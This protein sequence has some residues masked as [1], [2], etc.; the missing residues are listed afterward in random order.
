MNLA[1]NR[2]VM[3][4]KRNAIVQST[5]HRLFRLIL[6]ALLA[7]SLPVSLATAAP[8]PTTGNSIFVVDSLADDPDTDPGDGLCETGLGECTLRAAIMEAQS[9]A[10]PGPDT[11]D[12]SGL[13]GTI[14]L[15]NMLPFIESEL[16]I[17]GPEDADTLLIDGDYFSQHFRVEST[18]ALELI[19]MHLTNGSSKGN[20]GSIM[21]S[22]TLTLTGVIITNSSAGN[23]G[24][25]I[26]GGAGSVT[27]IDGGSEI[28]RVE[29]GNYASYG[30]GIAI[31]S[32][33]LTVD[34]SAISYNIAGSGGG[35][36][37]NWSGSVTIR[38]GS[39]IEGNTTQGSG[40]GDGQ[41][42]G[43]YNS[44]SAS[45]QIED[46]TLVGNSGRNGGGIYNNYSEATLV[47]TTVS[48]NLAS[49]SGGGIYED[50]ADSLYLY[51]VTIT[52]NTAD[53]NESGFGNGGGLAAGGFVYMYNTILA[54][55]EDLTPEG[56]VH[57]DC[58]VFNIAW[59][60]SSYNIVGDNAGCED[61]LING[62]N[63]NQ[64]GNAN[65]PLDPGLSGLVTK[66]GE[67][68]LH[69]IL[70]GSP[71]LDAGDLDGCREED[72]VPVYTDQRGMD[73]PQGAR[74]DVGAFEAAWPEIDDQFFSVLEFS[75][76]GTLVGEV[77]AED[78]NSVFAVDMAIIAGN[79]S[80]AF[81]ISPYDYELLVADGSQ[82]DP[83]ASPIFTLTLQ[84]TNT[85][86]LTDTG[87]VYVY[88][89]TDPLI[90][91]NTDDSGP[92][93]LR[94]AISTANE[95]PVSSTITF[96]IPGAGPHII[97]PLSD[98]PVVIS[99]MTI[100]GLTQPQG[101]VIVDGSLAGE[102]TGGL[103]IAAYQATVR[104]LTIQNFGNHGIVV[105]P[106][107]RLPA[108]GPSP[109]LIENNV[110]T[111][112]AGNGVTVINTSYVTIRDNSIYANGLLGIDLDGDGVTPNDIG[113]SDEGANGLQNFPVLLRAIP[114]GAQTIVEGRF[115]SSALQD[116]E[117]EFYASA[118]CNPSGFGEGQLLIGS[119]SLATDEDGNDR[120]SVTLP[121]ALGD[122]RF[123]TAL[124]TDEYGNTSEFSQ[125]IV[126]GP[127]N[128]SWPRA[129][130]MTLE[131]GAEAQTATI[132]HYV[133]KLGQSRWY[134]FEVEPDSRVTVE[135][136]NLPANY[137]V[138]IFKDIAALYE[139]LVNP[140][141]ADDLHQLGAEFAPDSFAP[142]SFAPDSFA[143]DSFAPDSF[144]PD[145]FAPDSFA[146][147]SFA[148]DSFAP[149]SFAPDSFAPD[150]HNP[151]TFNPDNFDPS[152]P[153]VDPQAYASAQVRSMVAFSGLG[154]T[155]DER[156][157][158]N[159]WLNSGD[160]YVRVRG[161][162]GAAS[163]DGPFQLNVSI[164]RGL[165]QNLDTTLVPPSLA[166]V[167]GG[168]KTVILFDP[169]RIEGDP[170]DI[171]LLLA[172]LQTLAARPEVQGVIIDVSLDARVAAANLQADD[173]VDCPQA[174][175]LVA[176]AI[177]Q[178]VQRYRTLNPLEY[179]VIV[180]N[181]DAIPFFRTPDRALLAPESNY[182]PPVFNQT[183]SQ[184]SLKLDYVLGQDAY[185]SS[186]DISLQSYYLPVPDLAVG[187]LV[188]T[189]SD[190][191]T[192]LDAYLA[193]DG[194]VVG[195]PSSAFVSGYDFLT[196]VAEEIDSLLEEAIGN[197]PTTL[198]A[199]R[200]QAPLDPLAWT[201]AQLIDAFLG[202]R[203]DLVFLAGHFSASSAL[204]ADFQ[205]RMTT[206][207][208]L[209]SSVDMTNAIIYSVGC[210]S[211]YNIVNL[212]GV[213]NVTREPDWAQAFAMKGATFI[214]GTGYQYGHTDFIAY[215][216][217]LY[218]NFTKQL[219]Y[220]TGPI[221]I[222][223]ALV[224][225]KQTYLAD[226]TILRGID[227]KS[228]LEATLFGLPMISVD[229]TGRLTP[230]SD[231]SVIGAL[232]NYA[233]DPGLTLG[234]SFADLSINPA[235]TPVTRT[236][237][238]TNDLSQTVVATY[239][240]GGD[241]LLLNPTEPVLPVMKRNV[242]APQVLAELA[243]GPALRG[244]GFRSG[245][246]T[247]L[248]N[249]VALTSAAAT[250]IR[251][252]QFPFRSQAF[253]PIRAW[254]VNYFDAL[255]NSPDG[256]TRLMV[257][258]AQFKSNGFTEID[259]TLRS[260]SDMEFRLFYSDNVGASSVTRQTAAHAPLANVP[261][262]AAPPAIVQ[263]TS[264][265]STVSVNV[266]VRVTSD[267]SA[268]VQEVWVTYTGAAGPFY[269]SWESLDLTQDPLD[270]TLWSGVLALPEG[271][272]WQD[273]RFIVQAVNGVGLVGVVTNFG[274]YYIP[275]ID[276]GQTSDGALPTSLELIAPPVSG[277]Y[278]TP[279]TFSAQ[280]TEVVRSGQGGGAGI[281]DQ[282]IEFGLGSQR[283]QIV[284]DAN[285]I[286][287]VDFPLMGLVQEDLIRVSFG[288]S[289]QYQQSS[290]QA[291]F[292][293]VKQSTALTVEPSPA[294]GQYSDNTDLLA[295]LIAGENRRLQQRTVF[296]VVGDLAETLS[297]T[298]TSITDFAGRAPA[299]PVNLPA[300][301]YPLTAY[302][303][304]EIPVGGGET[305]VLEDSRFVESVGLG[306]LIQTA[307]DAEVTYTGDLVFPSSK[308]FALTAFVVQDDDG[309]PGDLMLAQ[310]R[311][312][313][314]DSDNQVAADLTGSVDTGGN[315]TAEAPSLPA[316][317]YQLTVQVVGGFFASPASDPIDIQLLPPTAVTLAALAAEPAQAASLALAAL[318][319]V[320]LT[321]GLAALA[322]RRRLMRG[323]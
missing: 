224:A 7:I 311:Y 276:P 291:P 113:D 296:F 260:Y 222:G 162:N 95:L 132:S 68:P 214:G 309:S 134:K 150:E 154:G 18:G 158:V 12:L 60:D 152:V 273:V 203:H 20:G 305:V 252:V 216:E 184:A 278:G 178:I 136:S 86:G 82:L 176:D 19:S 289:S 307:E 221:P 318:L 24:G 52:D 5:H 238:N 4:K 265:T 317:N 72:G 22:G 153:I 226:T 25:A 246:Y 306:T 42:G 301:S 188:E 36:I 6:L 173:K 293:I 259:G 244:V 303:L 151:N 314:L 148:P 250:E 46:S 286:A 245:V 251:G 73:R 207:D 91:R 57:P 137:D 102:E 100:D 119:A 121:V 142:D 116:F 101:D 205:T 112:N 319:A 27:I 155:A 294:V 223:K 310:V 239:L 282:V 236:L 140:Q 96:D 267:P 183:A 81:E 32:G 299:G 161:R 11:I 321:A 268:G 316:G 17:I 23:D 14:T 49:G 215:S 320:L 33:S 168:F 62:S 191:M 10:F 43:V 219:R 231:P 201:G 290:T 3:S 272:D 254:N 128:D 300:G 51:N 63:D 253:Y 85:I 164:Q 204:A 292:E 138:L 65:N 171:A 156:A 169:N 61:Y 264:I 9:A 234:L 26:H 308:P 99:P 302:F 90:V 76:D 38:N 248:P 120:F 144:A 196:D 193:T 189:P 123:I 30:G 78:P 143:P 29:Q 202:Q 92:N 186:L 270:S 243:P 198:I 108:G 263:V 146:P 192:I 48:G 110:I 50:S 187:R 295:T 127:G 35:G 210:H 249:I 124:A 37:D 83:V 122:G 200:D 266:N 166:G 64:V 70:A 194:G 149:D 247:D 322:A 220:G 274:D 230:P 197:T 228:L 87:I 105:V 199:P 208:L 131:G 211:G 55:N 206:D 170:A 40:E 21:N 104:G 147:D 177:R 298:S 241:A 281:P 107:S 145:L 227:E 167:A 180:G 182:V 297:A 159:T 71:A 283:R 93:S 117:V 213:P 79:E 212:H 118:A 97:Q 280:L 103:A 288:G 54:G 106:P 284:T 31:N 240:Q 47:N 172:K 313:L 315:S 179:V 287:T 181:D 304:G 312:L 257:I 135:L 277:P 141:D 59:F 175:N 41:G 130:R 74:C 84:I 28:G 53:A 233:S 275:G 111:G 235:L 160:Y 125:C 44:S 256:I 109:S 114:D 209:A 98:L 1:P 75:P 185:G 80:G 139:S 174:K 88:V 195:T 45:L 129:F 39:I 89:M 285:G 69:A 242:T 15:N 34:N 323:A 258:P 126:T 163:L 2:E 271:Q 279:A 232:T 66:Y 77:L 13:S 165:C 269:G 225:A 8:S 67:P 157:V 58:S 133:D 261:A 229:L 237:S 56:P 115:N 262:L 217:Q 255:A 218:L 16:V 94:S 190:M